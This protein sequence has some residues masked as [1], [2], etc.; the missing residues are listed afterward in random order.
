MW[1]ASEDTVGISE[2]SQVGNIEKCNGGGSLLLQ[3]SERG[4]I[5]FDFNCCNQLLVPLRQ[6]QLSFHCFTKAWPLASPTKLTYKL[7][8]SLG[9]LSSL[10]HLDSIAVSLFVY[11]FF[12][13]TNSQYQ[14]QIQIKEQILRRAML[15]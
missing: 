8:L 3:P 15:V 5:R 9:V 12:S 1:V 10:A 7:D 11:A 13:L 2:K 4:T 14:K 6:I